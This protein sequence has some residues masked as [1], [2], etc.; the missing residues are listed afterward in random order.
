MQYPLCDFENQSLVLKIIFLTI[1]FSARYVIFHLLKYFSF[2]FLSLRKHVTLDQ[3]TI[4]KLLNFQYTYY[5]VT[6]TNKYL[7]NVT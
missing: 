1:F 6:V 3:Y 7:H 2:T 4:S 5:H